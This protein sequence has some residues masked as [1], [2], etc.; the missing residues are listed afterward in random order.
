MGLPIRFQA[1]HL[2]AI[3]HRLFMAA[4][5]PH[6]IADFVAHILVNANLAGHDSHGVQFLPM[7]LDRIEAGGITPDVEPVI[8]K[9]TATTL[10][11]DGKGGFGHYTIRQALYWAIDRAKEND[12]CCVNFTGLTHMGRLGEFAELAVAADCMVILTSGGGSKNSGNVTPF[13]GAQPALSTNP[14]AVGVPTGDDEPF[15]LD[16]AT[17]I[18]AGAKVRVAHNKGVDVPEGW[19]VDKHGNPTTNPADFEEGGGYLLPFGGHKGYALALLV[20]LLGGLAGNFDTARASMGGAFLQVIN[21]DSFSPS[22]DYQEGARAFLN[23][24]RSTPPAPGFDAVQVP[25]DFERRSRRERLAHGIEVPE[26]VCRR[27]EEW[28]VKLDV[29]LSE[30]ERDAAN[31]DRYQATS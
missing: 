12:V 5:T 13:G 26:P 15:I 4:G 2:H 17:S 1:N 22:A 25:G 9:E 31:I 6:P 21:I 30:A 10:L 11:V 14:I 3:A 29:S 19:I 8:A 23:G 20:C 24:L 16:F 27:I 7:Y 18:V 28:A